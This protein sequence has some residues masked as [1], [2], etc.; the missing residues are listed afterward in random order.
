MA[1]GVKE[2]VGLE[3]LGT[4]TLGG[5]GVQLLFSWWPPQNGT[6]EVREQGI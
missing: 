3:R 1:E 6:A 2:P 4:A 5:G